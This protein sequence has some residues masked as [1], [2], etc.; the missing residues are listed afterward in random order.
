MRIMILE[1]HLIQGEV[2]IF[3]SNSEF[4]YTHFDRVNIC[5]RWQNVCGYIFNYIT[6]KLIYPHDF[7][8]LR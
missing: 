8:I 5:I 3:A 2:N 4:R 1:N 6:G 7:G